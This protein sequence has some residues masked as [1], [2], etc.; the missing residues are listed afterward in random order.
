MFDFVFDNKR[1]TKNA[2]PTHVASGI[3][4]QE[5]Q[6]K[7]TFSKQNAVFLSINLKTNTY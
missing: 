7:N 3:F 1:T 2:V 5:I 4:L 6:G